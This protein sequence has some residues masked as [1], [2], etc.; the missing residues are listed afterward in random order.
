MILFFDQF[1]IPDSYS[2]Y[3]TSSFLNKIKELKFNNDIKLVSF[4]VIGL[5]TNVSVDLVIGNI[6]SELFSS[7]VAPY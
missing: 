3:S 5:F 2:Q 4:A 7:N 1:Y 6:A